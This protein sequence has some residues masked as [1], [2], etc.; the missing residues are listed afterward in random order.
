MKYK[1]IAEKLMERVAFRYS[2]TQE[3]YKYSQI[4]QNAVREQE[5]YNYIWFNSL[6]PMQHFQ[7]HFLIFYHNSKPSFICSQVF[8]RISASLQTEVL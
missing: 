1:N 2:N 3:S 7:I 4:F 8:N 5:F 6:D